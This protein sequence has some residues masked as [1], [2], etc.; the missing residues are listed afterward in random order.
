MHLSRDIGTHD[1]HQANSTFSS[2]RKHR[3]FEAIL[4]GPI[5]TDVHTKFHIAIQL[6]DRPTD[7]PDQGGSISTNQPNVM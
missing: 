3:G 5:A 6:S 2:R 4:H 1:A 7:Y